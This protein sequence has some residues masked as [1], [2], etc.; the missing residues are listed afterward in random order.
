MM[1]RILLVVFGLTLASSPAFAAK[2][3]VDQNKNE[4]SVSGKTTK[5]RAAQCKAAGGKWVTAKK[6]SAHK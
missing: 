1:K 4:V 6:A 2:H 5:A 3:C